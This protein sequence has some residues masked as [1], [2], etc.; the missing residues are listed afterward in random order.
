[1]S[2]WAA[3]RLALPTAI[4]LF[5]SSSSP[6]LS[7]RGEYIG[8]NMIKNEY[9]VSDGRVYEV[10]GRDGRGLPVC[11]LTNLKEIPEDKPLEKPEKTEEEPKVKPVKKRTTKK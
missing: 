1:M 2:S 8:V 7:G 6:C 11:R 5:K 10:I 3:Q 4:L 9:L